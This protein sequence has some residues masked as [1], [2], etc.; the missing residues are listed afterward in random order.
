MNRYVITFSKMGTICYISHLDLMR[1][2]RR[3]FKKAGIRLVYSQGFNP[4]PKM[5]FAQPLSLG[6]WGLREM[7][8]F[9]TVEEHDPAELQKTIASH[10]PE[11]IEIIDCRHL[12]GIRKT[13]AA[14]AAA[15]EYIIAIPV[16]EPVGM[17]GQDIK[18]KYMGQDSIITL[19]KQK[20]KKEPV[21]VDI[22][23]MIRSIEFTPEEEAL[24]V[25][26]V[27]D[28]GSVSNL[29]PELVIDTLLECLQMDIDRSEIAVM[30]KK[31]IFDKID[32]Q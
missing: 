19:K 10:M 2:F 9:E 7:M 1:M 23:P 8:E 26:A 17:T 25:T 29:S 21:E 32:R 11:G 3:T 13:L 20:K 14:A 16:T 18:D 4:H 30:R 12:K 22:K 24:F 5:G 27:L 15:A 28:S 31:I 6:Y